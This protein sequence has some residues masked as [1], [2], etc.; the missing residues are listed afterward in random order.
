[1]LQTQLAE[2]K[3]KR[4]SLM[5]TYQSSQSQTPP[6]KKLADL[7]PSQLD[8]QINTLD[9]QYNN[10][11]NEFRKT[12]QLGVNIDKE[13]QQ[14]TLKE[15]ERI[16]EQ[17]N[18]LI[19]I[20]K[21]RT[22]ESSMKQSKSPEEFLM[23]KNQIHLIATQLKNSPLKQPQQLQQTLPPIQPQQS[24]L[25]LQQQLQQSQ[26]P[27]QPQQ[28]LQNTLIQQ[29]LHSQQ[30]PFQ[31]TQPNQIHQT[32][33][34]SLQHQPIQLT[35]QNYTQLQSQQLFQPLQQQQQQQQQQILSQNYQQQLPIQTSQ[36][37]QYQQNNPSL[38]Q[39][40]IY[41]LPLSQVPIPLQQVNTQTPQHQQN[42][43]YTTNLQ[44]QPQQQQL[45]QQQQQQQQQQAQ[46]QSS[47]LQIEL[48]KQNF[49]IPDNQISRNINDNNL[50]PNYGELINLEKSV[51]ELQ[52]LSAT[53]NSNGNISNSLKS[54]VGM[55]ENDDSILE[56]QNEED[57]EG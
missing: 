41:S 3:S 37:L 21:I 10:L 39:Q 22:L 50:I 43:Q 55:N 33:Q 29:Q 15:L 38:Q 18:K 53:F 5:Q 56:I 28:S 6:T 34:S 36:Q 57:S 51:Y 17:K 48:E 13:F 52:K 14:K 27:I 25:K 20:K 44:Y 54:N 24:T 32:Q 1:L 19:S 8:F 16:L 9:Q 46:F 7:T 45:Q 40:T 26:S 42:L 35:P 47:H 12:S 11:F 4:D 49:S 23:Y 30:L 2:Q 31:Q